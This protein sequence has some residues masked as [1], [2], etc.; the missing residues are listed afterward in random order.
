MIESSAR[1]IREFGVDSVWSGVVPMG[2]K[3]TWA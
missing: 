2:W 3:P 1:Q